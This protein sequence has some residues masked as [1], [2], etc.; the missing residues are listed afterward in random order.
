MVA[1]ACWILGFAFAGST[2]IS[3]LSLLPDVIFPISVSYPDLEKL[4]DSPLTREILYGRELFLNTAFYLGPKGTV[5]HYLGNRMN[6]QNCHLDAGT[7]LFG[8]SLR[9]THGNYPQ[10]RDRN[11]SIITLADR[12][13]QCIQRPHNG[14]PLPH[15]SREMRALLSYF[16]WLGE[17]ARVGER[18]I[19]DEI[20]NLPYLNRAADPK[21]G[22][23][24]F[25]THCRRCH[26]EKG[27]GKLNE[28]GTYQY[29]PL[30]GLDSFT[31]G[32]SMHR[33]RKAAAFIK[34]NMPF[35][36]S[37]KNPVLSDAES[38]DVA[39]YITDERANPRP[40]IDVSNDYPNLAEKP[41]DYPY[42]PYADPFME[43]QHRFGPYEPIARFQKQSALMISKK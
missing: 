31:I 23:W 4:P 32:S 12:I 25:Q 17:S 15:E 38:Y 7:R 36:T 13:N 42:A 24:V 33:V 39:A 11:A 14:K 40:L 35:G 27:E 43:E 34:Y 6:C 10:Y 16:K 8:G 19:G 37:W 29:P 2:P 5:G 3:I 41:L 21:R 9:S 18:R 30:W 20:P 1:M 26:G 28:Q 22:E